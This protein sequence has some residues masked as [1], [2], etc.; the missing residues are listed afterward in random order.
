MLLLGLF[1]SVPL[2]WAADSTFNVYHRLYEPNQPEAFSTFT[3]RGTILIPGG[4]GDASFTPS[5]FLS[6][7]LTKFA[8]QL[9]VVKGALYQV[10]L[11]LDAKKPGQWDVVSAVKVC[12]LNQATT[13]TLIL[14]ATHDG[15]PYALDYFVAPTPHNGACPKKSPSTQ[16][17]MLSFATNIAHLNTTVETRLPRLPPLP[18]LRVPPPLTP[19]GEP[20]V[21][22]PEKSL[23]ARY[24]MYG[25]AI[26][27]ALMLS[28]GA[29]EEP[30]KK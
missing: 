23:F 4:Y 15:R 16:S 22:V 7:D 19:E 6:E 13:E 21:P 17:P 8:E 10:A 18:D 14:H 27:V 25:A 20:V 26:L 9:Q 12:H 11:E 29:E 28:G 30:A 1:A 5:P 24:W 2:V 3:A